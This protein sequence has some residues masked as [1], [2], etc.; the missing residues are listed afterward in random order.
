MESK[1]HDLL[2]FMLTLTQTRNI[3]KVC[4]LF[5]EA[6]NGFWPDVGFSVLRDDASPESDSVFPLETI[7][8][9]H[10]SVRV[11]SRRELS[12]ENHSLIKNCIRFLAVL[13]EKRI[14]EECLDKAHRELEARFVRFAENAGDVLYR[15]RVPDLTYEFIGPSCEYLFGAPPDSFYRDPNT[16][17]EFVHPDSK[18]EW[19]AACAARTRG[20]PPLVFKFRIL[21]PNGSIRWIQQRETVVADPE[22]VGLS[23]EGIARDVTEYVSHNEELIRTHETLRRRE[24]MLNS[25]FRAAPVGIGLVNNRVFGWTNQRIEEMTGYKREELE[26]RSSRILYPTD[27][28]FEYVGREKY[29]QIAQ[30]GTGTVETHWRRK[31]GEIIDVL[32]SS[33][34]LDLNDLSLGV[35]FSALDITERK[36][37][38]QQ[39]RQSEKMR[40]VGQLAGG[41]AHD[42]NNQLAGILGY[43][44]MLLELVSGDPVLTKY[45]ENI[46]TSTNRAADLTK[47]LLA[48]AG[49]GQVFRQSVD[50]N[51]IV[52]EVVSVLTRIVDRRI[53]IEKEPASEP[54]TVH[55]DTTEIQSAV[56]NLGINACDAMPRGGILRFAVA[57]V[58]IEEDEKNDSEAIILKAGPYV[59]VTVTDTGTGMDDETLSHIYEPFFTTKALGMGTGMGLAAVY[60][61]VRSLEGCIRVESIPGQGTKFIIFLPYENVSDDADKK[62]PVAE[63]K[64]M[65]PKARILLLDDEELVCGLAAKALKR[66]GHDVRAFTAAWDAL[67]AYNREWEAFDL[68]VL[69]LI[70]PVMNG[71]EVMKEM[72]KVNPAVKILVMSGFS[73]D[74]DFVDHDSICGLVRKPF[75]TNHLAKAVNVALE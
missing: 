45:A 43:S 11:R 66:Q 21:L 46:I 68:V 60:G 4:R 13:M 17:S 67:D 34:P 52:E 54:A 41:I 19:D 27:E 63:E 3:L 74:A 6:M 7:R 38:E 30:T 58:M 26:G 14:Q 73:D 8:G 32:L 1:S 23:I 31:D 10:G 71:F 42:F 24:T 28:D 56:L 48:F 2:V 62:T 20:D 25:I 57:V 69:D 29:R 59:R 37:L 33:T 44:D 65:G 39:L 5:E 9:R 50:V 49:K 40:A 72:R 36:Q 15:M 61:T 18:N 75:R 47:R 64:S 55:C 35:T 12:S 53:T 22:G 16:L 51:D 70:M